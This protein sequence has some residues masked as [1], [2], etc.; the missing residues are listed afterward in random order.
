MLQG[1]NYIAH[2]L[3]TAENSIRQLFKKIEKKSIEKLFVN[4]NAANSIKIIFDLYDLQ[5][6]DKQEEVQ[7]IINNFNSNSQRRNDFLKFIQ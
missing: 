1:G 7:K 4:I 3:D 5:Y 2:A 6:E